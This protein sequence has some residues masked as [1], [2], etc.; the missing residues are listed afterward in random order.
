VGQV[1]PALQE[2]FTERRGGG[3]RNQ[4][5]P[6]IT[7]NEPNMLIVRSSPSDFSA[8]QGVVTELDTPERADKPNYRIIQITQG[9]NVTKLADTVQQAVNEGAQ[10]Q[11]PSGGRGQKVPSITVTA[12][13]RLNALIVSGSPTLFDGAE[14]LAKAMEQMGPSG[15]RTV[16][17]VRTQ[18]LTADEIQ[19]LIDQLTGVEDSGRSRSSGR[20]SARRPSS[21]RSSGSPRPRSSQPS[22]PGGR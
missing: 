7:A 17:V 12:D 20:S 3:R 16:R 22:R 6:V 5:Q 14:E 15:G 18:N 21:N 11:A 9:V 1:L 19:G 13:T 8:I 2:L 4:E 10:A